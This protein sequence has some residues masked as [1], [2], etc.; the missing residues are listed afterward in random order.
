[1]PANT[2]FLYF[3]VKPGTCG[4]HAFSSS[5]AQFGRDEARYK[6]ARIDRGGKSPT[7]C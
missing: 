7:R 5:Q 3:V 6:Q 4:E 1:M 2:R